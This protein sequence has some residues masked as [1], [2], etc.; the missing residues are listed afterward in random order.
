M[1]LVC[2]LPRYIIEQC[3]DPSRA[4]R[5]KLDASVTMWQLNFS[6]LCYAVNVG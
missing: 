2:C 3:L 6:A 1:S 5:T 4:H